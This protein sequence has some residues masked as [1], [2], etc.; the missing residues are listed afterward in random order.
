MVGDVL[1]PF[2]GRATDKGRIRIRIRIRISKSTNI[3][4][5]NCIRFIFSYQTT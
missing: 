4:A 2:M 3:R 1:L 5:S